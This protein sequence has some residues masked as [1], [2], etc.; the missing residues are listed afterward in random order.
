[1]SARGETLEPGAPV[2]LFQSPVIGGGI[3]GLQGRQYD[4]G[5]DGRFLLNTQA[6]SNAPITLLMHWTP[7]APQ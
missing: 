2:V 4:V 1:M 6:E 5:R 3:D 7:A